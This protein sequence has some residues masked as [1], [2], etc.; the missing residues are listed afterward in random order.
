MMPRDDRDPRA[1]PTRGP[2]GNMI[3]PTKVLSAIGGGV[4]RRPCNVDQHELDIT[5]K[6]SDSVF[7]AALHE[8]GL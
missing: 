3:V 1:S 8:L 6:G 4:G 7:C 2:L 5:V